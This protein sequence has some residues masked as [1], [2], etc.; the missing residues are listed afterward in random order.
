MNDIGWN[1]NTGADGR[2]CGIAGWYVLMFRVSK[3]VWYLHINSHANWNP[4]VAICI[5]NAKFRGRP[6]QRPISRSPANISDSGYLM[7]RVE[8][9]LRLI[10]LLI[11]MLILSLALN[12]SC[13]SQQWSIFVKRAET[14]AR[15]LCLGIP[16][17]SPKRTAESEVGVLASCPSMPGLIALPHTPPMGWMTF[18]SLGVG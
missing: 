16:P 14:M 1:T 13:S 9:V 11:T 18:A 10:V 8:A 3:S 17:T 12:S 7:F 6:A 5:G 4:Y 2:N 15:L